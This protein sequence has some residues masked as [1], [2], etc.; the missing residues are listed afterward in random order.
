MHCLN[1]SFDI[2]FIFFFHVHVWFWFNYVMKLKGFAKVSY[3]WI[4]CWK[5]R[6][7]SWSFPTVSESNQLTCLDDVE[8]LPCFVLKWIWRKIHQLEE[9]LRLLNNSLKTLK[10]KE[11]KVNNIKAITWRIHFY[12]ISMLIYC[13]RIILIR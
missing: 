5:I 12:H 7:Q 2:L 13:C 4:W 8:I 10:L 3:A 9:E 1:V 11:E 6:R